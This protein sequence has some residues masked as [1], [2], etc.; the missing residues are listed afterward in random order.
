MQTYWKTFIWEEWGKY[1]NR[2]CTAPGVSFIYQDHWRTC[3]PLFSCAGSPRPL[4]LC[5]RGPSYHHNRQSNLVSSVWCWFCRHG[6]WT[7]SLEI[8]KNVDEAGQYVVWPEALQEDPARSMY[9]V[10]CRGN[11]RVLDMAGPWNVCQEKL[12]ESSRAFTRKP[13]WA[14]D[15]GLKRWCYS[16]AQTMLPCAVNVEHGDPQALRRDFGLWNSMGTVTVMGTLELW[17]NAFCLTRWPWNTKLWFECE[18]THPDLY[19][20][21]LGPELVVLFWKIMVPLFGVHW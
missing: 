14:A 12:H 4:L 11:Y 2:G 17:L 18:M 7:L 6:L 21:I 16:N 1:L 3:F 5:W 10:S 20:W 15:E 19:I 8:L 13:A 9:A